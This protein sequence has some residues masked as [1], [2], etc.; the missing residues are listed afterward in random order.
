MKKLFTALLTVVLGGFSASAQVICYVEAPAALEGNLD[1]TWA[2]PAGG[3]GTPDLNIPANAITREVVVVRD[4][5]PGDSLGCTAITNAVDVA[6]KIA[7]IYRGTCEF[8]VKA[9]NAQNA[10]AHGVLIVNNVPGAPIA[11]G[12]G[13]QGGNV[14]IPTA[15]ITFDEAAT[16][17]PE[18]DAG[19]VIVFLGSKAGFYD[20]DLGFFP[21]NIMPSSSAMRPSLISQTAGEFSVIPSAWV[22]NYGSQDQTGVTLT[23]NIEIGGTVLYNQSVTHPAVLAS[24]DS[25]LLTLPV[26]SQ[27]SYPQAY[28]SF[29]YNVNSAATDEFPND[30]SVVADF[31]LTEDIFSYGRADQTTMLPITSASYRPGGG[32][33]YT[34]CIH[35][36]DANAGRLRLEGLYVG[37]IAAA[38]VTTGLVGMDFEISVIEWQ[39]Q[40]TNLDDPNFGINSLVDL[41]FGNYTYTADLQ[42]EP[43]YVPFDI[44][45]T[46][47]DNNR[48]LFCVTP[49]IA[50]MYIGHN[51]NVDMT[52]KIATD[53]QPVSPLF[54][55][56]T[57]YALGFGEDVVPSIG[58]K[59]VDVNVSVPEEIVHNLT[60]FPNPVA[61][62]LFIP[63]NGFDNVT[64]LEVFDMTG[65]LVLTE[66]F[67]NA[68]G[69]L[70][71]NVSSLASG[72]YTFRLLNSLE[73]N[74]SFNVVVRK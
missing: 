74:T 21:R 37:A 33:D 41:S 25:V 68:S 67:N 32:G 28:Y 36:M 65:K 6:G 39:D 48:Y 7:L 38:A 23:A 62:M 64:L 47:V 53:R 71:V 18:I 31:A 54:S 35:F 40:F 26:F 1:F 49:L 29:S 10:G 58:A 52:R 30:N 5:T 20:Y 8:G 12:P 22:F 2:D 73:K 15:M 27:F 55:T 61:E 11:M 34:Q 42:N 17:R 13:A 56:G 66:N 57:F 60:P 44:P 63:L 59:L 72:Q 4:A 45:V 43:V 46:L 9:L 24:G 14:I 51:N 70:S 19:N 69:E 3:W 16:L 50:D